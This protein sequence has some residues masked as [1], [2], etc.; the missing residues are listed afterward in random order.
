MPPDR[1][2]DS[3]ED[4]LSRRKDS[5]RAANGTALMC[6]LERSPQW[7]SSGANGEC[8]CHAVREEAE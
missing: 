7:T 2:D 8:F 3:A 6:N 1:G 5:H 4:L